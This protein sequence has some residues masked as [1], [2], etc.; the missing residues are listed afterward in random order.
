MTHTKGLPRSV[1]LLVALATLLL[2]APLMALCVALVRA[3]SGAP[4]FFRQQRM[5]QGGRPFTL[6]KF[7]TMRESSAD[8]PQVTAEGDTRITRAGHLM[9]RLKLDELPQLWNV[10]RGDMSLVGPRPEALVYVDPT[11]PRWREV[12]GVRPGLTDPVTIALRNEQQLLAQVVDDREAFYLN[13][14]QPFKLRGYVAYLDRRSWR[15]D[16]Q[17][18]WNTLVAVLAPSRT[19]VFTL[20]EIKASV[21]APR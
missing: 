14:L 20:D 3:S 21:S 11:E 4:V 7:R 18:L 5:G 15:T 2:L 1:E 8:A 6:L 12:L 19:P 10:V 13:T 17:V 16:V 9:R